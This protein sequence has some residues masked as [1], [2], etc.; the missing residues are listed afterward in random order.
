MSW[1]AETYWDTKEY[2]ENLRDNGVTHNEAIESYNSGIKHPLVYLKARN[3]IGHDETIHAIKN[4]IKPMEIHWYAYA[5]HYGASD[6]QI[7]SAYKLG[8]D[9]HDYA[10][11]LEI[12]ATHDEILDMHAKH[13]DMDSY[14]N[15]RKAGATH[16]EYIDACLNKKILQH[17]YAQ[18]REYGATHNEVLDAHSKG[19]N[20]Q[21]YANQRGWGKT[22]TE[23]LIKLNPNYNPWDDVFNK[24]SSTN[25]ITDEELN[26]AKFKGL[27]LTHY[28]YARTVGATHNEILDAHSK[29]FDLNYYG[30]AREYGATH[31]EILDM[32]SKGLDL[33]YYGYAREFGATHNEILDAKSKGLDLTHYA[34]A[35]TVG[36]THNEILDAH[37]KSFNLNDY[38]YAR[39]YG[40]THNEVLDAYSKGLN[41]FYNGFAR[42]HGAT[43][44]ETLDAHSKGLNIF[45]Y[46][47]ARKYGANHKEA[48]DAYSKG[49]DLRDYSD[50]RQY[51]VTHEEALTELL[52]NYNP[53]DD[54]FNKNSSTNRSV[55]QIV[56]DTTIGVGKRIHELRFNNGMPLDKAISAVGE[57]ANYMSRDKLNKAYH[58]HL[59]NSLKNGVEDPHEESFMQ[60]ELNTR[61]SSKWYLASEKVMPSS[62]HNPWENNPID[63]DSIGTLPGE[64]DKMPCPCPD[65]RCKLTKGDLRHGTMTGYSYNCKCRPCRDAKVQYNRKY[66]KNN[67]IKPSDPV[68]PNVDQQNILTQ[69]S[70]E[71]MNNDVDDPRHGTTRGYDI[72]C[73]CDPC[74]SARNEYDR[75]YRKNKKNSKKWYLAS[76]EPT[77]E[78]KNDARAKGINLYDYGKAREHGA[79][80]NEILDMHSKGLG[81]HDYA[82]ARQRGATHNEILEA[83]SNGINLH[84]YAYARQ[85]DVNHNEALE[86]DS[87]GINLRDYANVRYSA[88]HNEILDAH[89]KG[90][91]IFDYGCARRYGATH[92]EILD[93]HSKSLDLLRYATARRYGATHNEILDANS[94]GISLRDYAYTRSSDANHEQALTEFLPDYNPWDDI[95]NKNSSKYEDCHFC[96]GSSHM[97][98]SAAKAKPFHNLDEEVV[99]LPR[100]YYEPRE[101]NLIYPDNMV[102]KQNGNGPG[103]RKLFRRVPMPWNSNDVD[104]NDIPNFGKD[105]NSEG[106]SASLEEHRCPMCGDHFENDDKAV[107]WNPQQDKSG[108]GDFISDLLPYHEKCMR[109]VQIHC[110]HLRNRSSDE[111]VQGTYGGLMSDLKNR[112]DSSAVSLYNKKNKK[113]A[114]S[115]YTNEE[116]NEAKSKGIRISDY[117]YARGYNNITHNEILDSHSKGIDINGYVNARAFGATHNEVLDARSNGIN[118]HDYAYAR[119]YKNITHN[120][121]L[122]AHSKGFNL[123]DYANARGYKNATHNE[124]LDAHSK[125]LD[126]SK[127][128]NLENYGYARYYA[129]HNEIL[130]ADSKGLDLNDY[131]KAREHGINHEQTLIKHEQALIKSAP[132]YS[133]WDSIFNKNSSKWYLA[134]SEL[135]NEEINEAKAKGIDLNDYTTAR[136]HSATHNEILDAHSKGINLNDYGYAREHGATHNELLEAHSKDINLYNYATVRRYGVTHN[137]ALDMQSKGINIRDYIFARNY[138]ATHKEIL[139]ADSKGIDLNDYTT[140]RYHNANHE[141]VLTQLVPDYNP[142][143]DVFNKNSSS[144]YNKEMQEAYDKVG[145][146]PRDYV[147]SREAGATHKEIM[148]AA[149]TGSYSDGTWI[150]PVSYWKAREVGASHAEAMDANKHGV[151]LSDY[152]ALRRSGASHE[153]A[154]DADNKTQDLFNY[155]LSRMV[156]ASHKEAMEVHDLGYDKDYHLIYARCQN[157]KDTLDLIS[158][159][160]DREDYGY[161]VDDGHA[162]HEEIMD[163]YHKGM[164]SD[165]GFLRKVGA[166]HQD[167]LELHANNIHTLN[168]IIDRRNGFTHAE[169][170]QKQIPEYDAWAD[171]FNKKGSSSLSVPCPSESKSMYI[172]QG[173][174]TYLGPDDK[175][176]R[177]Y[178]QS[179]SQ[180]HI[181]GCYTDED[182]KNFAETI[183]VGKINDHLAYH[184]ADA[185][186]HYNLLHGSLQTRCDLRYIFKETEKNMWQCDQNYN[187]WEDV[188][189]KK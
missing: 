10:R 145:W 48:L 16:S 2:Y 27:N 15:A 66:N 104:I 31:N 5:R 29:S 146:E 55:S 39:N 161:A 127:G 158:H 156:G 172:P 30:Y 138:G 147:K 150:H 118:L 44:N 60:S 128:F 171:V 37:S 119:G 14:A 176:K 124:I 7:R 19:V 123:R 99:G 79:T 117:I 38:N 148:E 103:D 74:K 120:E 185:L 154:I 162:K 49:L 17:P 52:P 144:N 131:G 160:F 80:H 72:G 6:E 41:L 174:G 133:P 188:F 149:S 125:G 86:A 164:L 76:I 180:D 40:V 143:D 173:D 122:D 100:P 137:E 163:A 187:P 121:I 113:K 106:T 136:Y 63:I 96:G 165:Y 61:T 153:E 110:P 1:D 28:G 141:Q 22:H 59:T 58:K 35:R 33:N 182:A 135:T 89:S 34:N 167:V 98:H 170:M 166:S 179:W 183:K 132:D 65:D 85:Y 81:L 56:G 53:W 78:E 157:H 32:H 84:D 73:R 95:F 178:K 77:D 3:L 36:A 90:L 47:Y 25:E 83:R 152:G 75:E 20:M 111:F 8:I 23:A 42:G 91:D 9:S 116:K 12:G 115:E 92:N 134:S 93:A 64:K 68:T 107:A 54:V 108:G 142:W 45:D 181:F 57:Q 159:G 18:C 24:N 43:H 62:E 102:Q 69:Y 189:N 186:M 155:C 4:G 67:N 129:T 82:Y 130:D 169:A 46:G 114:S 97:Y 94:K 101:K 177:C 26:D 71:N 105:D 87:K 11:A 168:Y 126:F 109:L 139:E 70:V 88:T 50:A 51:G 151:E 140:A 13:A 175:C 184:Y 21:Q 112:E